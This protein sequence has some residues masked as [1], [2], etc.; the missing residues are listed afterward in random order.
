MFVCVCVHV[1]VC[2][3]EEK[4]PLKQLTH[5]SGVMLGCC[6]CVSMCVVYIACASIRLTVS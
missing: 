1:C 2:V 6:V 3:C 4:H 5:N